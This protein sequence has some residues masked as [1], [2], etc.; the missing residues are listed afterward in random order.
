MHLWLVLFLLF[1]II[2]PKVLFLRER[3]IPSRS[4]ELHSVELLKLFGAMGFMNQADNVGSV[5]S[6]S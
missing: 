5:E 3:I 4:V 6:C 1:E 2:E